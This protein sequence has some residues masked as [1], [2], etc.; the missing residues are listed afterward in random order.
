MH[1]YFYPIWWVVAIISTVY[2]F[3]WDI[4]C[5]F[6]FLEEG[7]NYPLRNKLAYKNKYFYYIGGCINL[8]LRFAWILTCSPEIIHGLIRPEF[9]AFI[10]YTLEVLRRGMW[11]FIRVELK[12]IELCKDFKVTLNIDLPFK[13]NKDG[14]LVLKDKNF[15]DVLKF[16]NRLERIKENINVQN[17]L[18]NK[19]YKENFSNSISMTIVREKD[20]DFRKDLNDYID[21][22]KHEALTNLSIVQNI[23]KDK[24]TTVIDEELKSN[25]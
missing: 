22:Y 9:F 13:K 8:F 18:L 5:D 7:E 21:H 23:H 24:E 6:G 16:T 4:K 12:H 10:I 11:N 15:N 20:E 3:S 2:S 25:L 14:Q 1:P 19:V 17:K